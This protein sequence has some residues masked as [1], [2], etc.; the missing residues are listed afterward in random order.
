MLAEAGA[1][2][3]SAGAATP[4]WIVNRSLK[5]NKRKKSIQSGVVAAALQNQAVRA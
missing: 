3:W 2:I 4:L 1:K 5:N